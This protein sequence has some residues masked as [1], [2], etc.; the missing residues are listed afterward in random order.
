MRRLVNVELSQIHFYLEQGS[1]RVCCDTPILVSYKILKIDITR[2]HSSRMGQSES[3]QC[4]GCRK[5]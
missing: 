5:F 3:S 4:P 1:D 2:R